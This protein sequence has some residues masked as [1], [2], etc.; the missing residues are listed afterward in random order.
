LTARV[1]PRHQGLGNRFASGLIR[2]FS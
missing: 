1:L 2:W